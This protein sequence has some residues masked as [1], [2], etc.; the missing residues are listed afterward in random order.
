MYDITE[1]RYARSGDV[2]IAYQVLGDGPF[3][4]VRIP[5]SISN[6]EVMWQVP[7]L[8]SFVTAL[9]EFSRLLHFDKR[10]SGLSDRIAG[11]A[12]LEER[13]DDVRAVMD[14]TGSER[15]AIF[16]ISEGGPMSLLFAAT[17]PERT[18]ALVLY[19]SFARAL[20]AP[21]YPWGPTEADFRRE[22]DEEERRW[23]E[24]A[25]M[26]EFARALAPD[27]DESQLEQIATLLRQS[28]S[29]GTIAAMNRMNMQIDVR[30]VL[31]SIRVPTLIL[32]RTGDTTVPVEGARHIAKAI[33]GAELVELPG[34]AHVPTSGDVDLIV[35]TVREFLVDVWERRAWEEVDRDR[36][37]ATVLFTDI[38]GS[39]AKA[40]E[41]GDARWRQLL[42]EHHTLVRRQLARHRGVEV[43]TAGD[44]FFAT[45]DGPARAIHCA[46]AISHDVRQLG[47]EIR[48]GLH[49]G[50]CEMHD[51]GVGGIAVHIGARVA[52]E[53]GPGEVLVSSTV[54]DL[55]AGSEIEFDD[56]GVADLKGVPGEWR[57]F[58]VHLR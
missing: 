32:H 40:V 15:A 51:G 4:V 48:A 57:L 6:I 49:T 27:V 20:W 39:T 37:L 29:P 2:S 24:P 56:R 50:E 23:G 42:G 5:G 11:Y 22:A 41:L 10:G 33:P 47:L 16:G 53:A 34:V 58:A 18:M 14:A 9:A 52:A 19:G 46:A 44:G 36:I 38:V 25:F 26:L 35:E 13:M 28:A 17:Y 21:D 55:V 43:D 31:S 3:D 7:P 45:F 30:H 8:A 54:R 12:T 1:T